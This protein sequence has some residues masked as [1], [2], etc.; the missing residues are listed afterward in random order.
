MMKK[1]F[2]VAVTLALL[3]GLNACSTMVPGRIVY[4]D[5]SFP[6]DQMEDVKAVVLVTDK[7]EFRFYG[8][9]G[10]GMEECVLPTPDTETK[11]AKSSLPVCRGMTKDSAVTS[12]QALPVL[13]SNSLQCMTFG[14]DASG[15]LY[16]I[17]WEVP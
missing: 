16:Q 14:P 11:Q 2:A 4:D 5:K 3:A 12:I 8:K 6:I 13:K 17:C 7:G 15:H 10:K 1:L 9:D